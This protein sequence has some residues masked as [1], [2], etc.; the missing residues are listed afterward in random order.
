MKICLLILLT[1][2]STLYCSGIVNFKLTDVDSPPTEIIWCGTSRDSLLVLT[3]KNSVYRSDDKGFSFK[4]MND[5]LLH[6]G[7]Q[8]LEEHENEIGKV[9]RILESPIDKSLLILLGTHGINWIGEDCGRKVKALNHGR[10]IQEYAFHPLE[11]DWG[12]ASALTKCEDFVDQPCRIYKELYVTRDLGTNWDFIGSYVTQFGWGIHDDTNIKSGIPKERILV[13]LQMKGKGHQNEVGWNYKIDFIYSDDFFKTKRIGAHKGNKFLLTKNHIFVAQVAD[14]ESQDVT[15]LVAS[16]HEKVYNF[17]HIEN[18][19]HTIKDHSYTFLDTQDTVFLHINHLGENSKYGNVY[20][21]DLTGT[22]YSLSLRY[23]VR[24]DYDHKCDFHKIESIEASYIANVI[25]NYF[26]NDAEMA[27][28]EEE[29]IETDSMDENAV[30]KRDQRDLRHIFNNYIETLIT[31][32]KGG[33]WKR[34]KAPSRDSEGRKYDCDNHCFLNLH[35]ISG[36][37]AGFYSVDTAAGIVIGNGNVGKYL[38]HEV[39]ETS[40]FLSRDGGLNWFEIR[41][42]SHIYEMG[43]HGAIIVIADDHNPTNIVYYTWDEGMTWQEIKISTDKIMI[44]NIIIEPKS[45][46][47]NFVVY[48]E[49][50]RKGEKK[51]FIIGIDFSSLHEPQCRNPD[52]PDTDSSDYET[53]TP[54]DGRL[55]QECLMGKKTTYVRRKRK[56]ECYNGLDFERKT[57]VKHCDCSDDDYECDYGFARSYLSDPCTPINGNLHNINDHAP[58]ENCHNTYTISKGYLKIPGNVCE[59][60]VKY[61]PIVIP[62]PNRLLLNLGKISLVLLIAVGAILIYFVGMHFIKIKKNDNK[63][64]YLDIVYIFIIIGL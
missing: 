34:V 38:S 33:S 50:T 26:M 16:S 47:Q 49:A 56:A 1:F 48:G 55:G 20:I 24:S 2:L 39:A 36:D 32:N 41:K 63:H 27:I 18:H 57:E 23:N 29:E 3:E 43:D 4:K 14:Q 9:S 53:W 59:N 51:G 52:S 61:D 10:K 44:K 54:N 58:P 25:D 35:G 30:Q 45:T 62:C 21:S 37:F 7:Q 11:R 17:Q 6:S 5:V 12:L 15:L 42:G 22:R 64:D 31:F 60:G 8:E 13:T 19:S 46:S 28:E 40:T